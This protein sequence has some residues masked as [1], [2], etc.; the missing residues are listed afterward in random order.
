[1]LKIV[2][3]CWSVLF[4][5]SKLGRPEFSGLWLCF[6][7]VGDVDALLVS[8]GTSWARRYLA[9]A[10]SILGRGKL[11]Q[12]RAQSSFCAHSKERRG[13]IFPAFS[14]VDCLREKCQAT[15]NR[16]RNLAVPSVCKKLGNWFE[17]FWL[18]T[19]E[20]CPLHQRKSDKYTESLTES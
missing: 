16:L 6:E 12:S 11:H 3:V 7:T 5:K 14:I 8:L 18:L 4:S 15:L 9:F 2:E 20:D 19:L 13:R 10:F 1:M 17:H